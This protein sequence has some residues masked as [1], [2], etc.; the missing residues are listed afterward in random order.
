M[1]AMLQQ[2][3]V[4]GGNDQGERLDNQKLTRALNNTMFKKMLWTTRLGSNPESQP[5]VCVCVVHSTMVPL[6]WNQ[7]KG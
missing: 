7:Q 3:P 4:G 6:K 5:D 2:K 1:W